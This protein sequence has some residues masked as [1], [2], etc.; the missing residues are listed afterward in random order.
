MYNQITIIITSINKLNRNIQNLSSNSKKKNWSFILI[1]DKKSP[2]NFFLKYGKYYNIRDQ[3]KTKINF[4]KICPL[5]NYARKNIGYLLAIKNKTEVIIETDDDNYPKKNF[6]TT[7]KLMHKVSEI[8][9]KD[10]VNIYDLFLKEKKL[11]WPRGLPLNFVKKN[12]IRLTKKKKLQKFYLQQGVCDINPDVDAIY[13]LI[14]D[15]INIKFKNNFSVSLGKAYSPFNSQNTIWFKEIFP[16]LYLPVLCSMRA[17][18]IIRGLVAMR[19]LQNDNKKSLFY[20]TTVFQKRNEHDLFRDFEDEIPIY[21]NSKKIV[22]ILNGLK[23]KK[24]KKF[25]SQNLQRCYKNL[26]LHKIIDKKEYVYLNSW[27]KSLKK[28]LN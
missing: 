15:K 7:P 10:W 4:A 16:L 28:I 3:K 8:T 12:K 24:G 18:D 13:R 27:L 9:N 23:L 14:N 26:I 21:L 11:I 20:G 2:K 6:F 1:G 22:E 5:N 25:Y 19:I 17:T